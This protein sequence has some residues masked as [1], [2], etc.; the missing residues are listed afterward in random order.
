[1]SR[2]FT[3]E[4]D[5]QVGRSD[6]H[7]INPFDI[8]VE[9]EWRGRYMAPSEADI[10]RLARSFAEKGQLQNVCVRALPDKSIKAVSGFTRIA[11][12]RLLRV[13]FEDAEGNRIQ[14]ETFKVKFVVTTDA[15]DLAALVNNSTENVMRNDLSP[16]DR[17]FSALRLKE[18]GYKQKDIADLFN[19]D[20]PA[21]SRLI[22]LTTL[23]DVALDMLHS[24]R[25]KQAAAMRLFDV[26]EEDREAAVRAATAEG[27]G[28]I[29]VPIMNSAIFSVAQGKKKAEAANYPPVTSLT[30]QKPTSASVVDAAPVDTEAAADAPE[31][32]EPPFDV[33]EQQVDRDAAEPVQATTVPHA[34]RIMNDDKH[35]E[36][37]KAKGASED[38]AVLTA[39]EIVGLLQKIRQNHSVLS[40]AMNAII[41]VAKG[42]Q[43]VAQL[44]KALTEE[45]G[46]K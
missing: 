42:V 34:A 32:D 8:I 43:S 31:D 29:T 5:E 24:G 44:N 23:P 28:D 40:P 41:A 4:S 39:G 46:G 3:T 13:G 33:D 18:N 1:M 21:V 16:A 36:A 37:K 27:D 17:A 2:T 19:I 15:D 10:K 12:A 45:Y 9:E 26:E 14:D 22:K 25:M 30:P 38:K 11:A 35:L 20:E 7:S 6:I